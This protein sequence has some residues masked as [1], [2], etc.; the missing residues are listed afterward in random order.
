VDTVLGLIGLVFFVAGVIGLAAGVTYLV[1]KI[2]PTQREK[3][4]TADAPG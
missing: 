3:K 1:I 2:S 4:R